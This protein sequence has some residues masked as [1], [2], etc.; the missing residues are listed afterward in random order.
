MTV[1]YIKKARGKLSGKSWIDPDALAP[2]NQ[3][4][5]VEIND[6]SGDIVVRA[7]IMLSVSRRPDSDMRVS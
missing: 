5:P 2:G 7:D 3:T 1:Q 4:V 6:M